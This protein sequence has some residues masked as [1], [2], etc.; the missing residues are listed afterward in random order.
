[1]APAIDA[2]SEREPGAGG[3]RRAVA[4]GEPVA[5]PRASATDACDVCSA[6]HPSVVRRLPGGTVVTRCRSC[7]L[8]ALAPLPTPAHLAAHYSQYYLT[9]VADAAR[10]DRLVAM[11]GPILDYLLGHVRGGQPVSV[12]DYGFG[13]GAFL[14]CV[15]RRGHR[16]TGAD[17]SPQNVAQLTGTAEIRLVDL[18]NDAEAAGLRRE[19]FDVITLFQV[20]EHA[21]D[22]LGLLTDLAS[23]QERGGLIY[24]EC[25]N[26]AAMWALVKNPAH[27]LHDS[28]SWNSLKYPEHLHGF[29]RRSIGELLTRAG[30]DVLE[31]SDYSYRDGLH[32]VESEFWWPRLGS[33]QLTLPGLVRSMIPIFDGAASALFKAGSGLYAL[34]RKR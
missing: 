14:Q 24:L 15:A 20:I 19:R 11:H 17:L 3:S 29:D 9:R 23:L 31:R 33:G 12:L 2:A 34:G 8:T 25:P 6:P 21:R 28:P 13:G 10:Q 26:D 18:S 1:M 30:Y 5:S 27:W 4:D 16:A 22:P 32:Q 7:N